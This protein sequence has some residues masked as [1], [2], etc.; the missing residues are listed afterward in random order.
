MNKFKILLE[1]FLRASLLNYKLKNDVNFNTK[2]RIYKLQSTTA[3]PRSSL[4]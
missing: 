1:G 2:K 4:Q 3:R